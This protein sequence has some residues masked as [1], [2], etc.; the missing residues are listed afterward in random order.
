ME[1]SVSTLRPTISVTRSTSWGPSPPSSTITVSSRTLLV[2]SARRPITQPPSA[3][4]TAP[5]SADTQWSTSMAPHANTSGPNTAMVTILVVQAGWGFG[6]PD[7]HWTPCISGH[8]N[9]LD[10]ST[11]MDK[12]ASGVATTLMTVLPSMI[13]FSPLKT[14]DIQTLYYLDVLATLITCGFTLFFRVDSWTTLRKGK[15]WNVT[16]ILC[17]IDIDAIYYHT[18]SR[19]QDS[20]IPDRITSAQSSSSNVISENTGVAL[21]SGNPSPLPAVDI[22]IP[23]L[24]RLYERGKLE[25]LQQVAFCTSALPEGIEF[26]SMSTA[27]I[28]NQ[29]GQNE[30]LKQQQR[31]SW[32]LPHLFQI[33][34]KILSIEWER[35]NKPHPMVLVIRP[36]RDPS[37]QKVNMH[38]L[39]G[40][41]QVLHLG[42]VS[43]LFGSIALSSLFLTLGFVATFVSAVAFSRLAS[44]NLCA[45][46]E[47]RLGLT[48]IEYRTEREW[49]AIWFVLNSM[50][51]CLVE[52]KNSSYRY[53][54]GFRPHQCT[55]AEEDPD[56]AA[57]A[58]TRDPDW[59]NIPMPNTDMLKA[60]TQV[61]DVKTISCFNVRRF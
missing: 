1:P 9:Y 7:F 33:T 48:I 21:E 37:Q 35:L 20:S 26:G 27:G 16:D 14:A 31:P 47:K 10:S 29:P 43:F 22:D 15:I 57:D 54:N 53:A 36:S 25:K 24:K 40:Y 50:P 34:F 45:W 49:V 55:E 32:R 18:R 60:N 6:G 51:G 8:N 4:T 52:S 59:G 44:I 39:S 5:E 13:A 61:P 3:M 30:A 11:E 28:Q 2:S 17:K 23:R 58:N 56:I 41:L 12:W 42:G 46:L 38:W 19:R